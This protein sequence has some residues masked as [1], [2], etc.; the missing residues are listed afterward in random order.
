[1][2]YQD[3]LS[4]GR[5]DSEYWY[6]KGIRILFE[7]LLNSFLK[8]QRESTPKRKILNIGSGMGEELDLY[9]QFGDIFSIDVNQEIAKHWPE[10][11]A[12]RFYLM[13]AEKLA[14]QGETFDAILAI[15][16]L[17]HIEHDGAAMAEM[18]RV[19]KPAGL[20]FVLIPMHAWIYGPMDR[21]ALHYRRYSKKGFVQLIGHAFDVKLINWWLSAVALP[22][23]ALKLIRKCLTPKSEASELV[24]LPKMLND[25][26]TFL[27]KC[28]V[29]A[30]TNRIPLPF[31]L[32][33]VAVLQKKS[34]NITYRPMNQ[35]NMAESFA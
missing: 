30:I 14:F 35:P 19:L 33:M 24:P 18:I 28:D 20:L 25:F 12:S 34:E 3:Y 15:D 16:V 2:D 17:E 1:M 8:D 5:I 32:S 11:Y 22:G 10:K 26:L 9:S 31:G 7:K 23:G 6:F 4:L 29:F 13:N 27:M 21:Y